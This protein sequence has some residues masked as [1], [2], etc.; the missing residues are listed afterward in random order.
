[1]PL[2]VLHQIK[3]LCKSIPKVEWSGILF[4]TTEGS[5]EKPASFKI[6]LKTILPL[7]MG[8]SAFTEYALDER[9]INFLEEDFD[10]RAQ[11]K[12]GHIHSHNV[13]G[14][15]FSGTDLAELNDNAPSHNFYLS[16]IVNNYMDF[17]AKVAFIGVAQRDIKQVPYM[18]MNS[19]GKTYE[20]EK[21]DFVVNEN[22]M[23]VYDCEINSQKEVI[24]VEEVFS[25]QV[26]KIMEPK[27]K[28][29]YKPQHNPNVPAIVDKNK[30]NPGYNKFRNNHRKNKD[31]NPFNQQKREEDWTSEHNF[32]DFNFNIQEVMEE[33]LNKYSEREVRITNFV[34]QLFNFAS[35][36]VPEDED[37]ADVLEILV[38]FEM[39]PMDIA[40]CI[41]QEYDKDFAT[42]FPEANAADFVQYT[43][44]ALDLLEDFKNYYP[45]IG[46]TIKI[47]TSMITKFV[48][49]DTAKRQQP[50]GQV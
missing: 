18:A 14:V 43:N 45:E 6:T 29:E 15:F 38:E 3:Y 46:M 21:Q 5:I 30:Q 11:W 49:H 47:I 7:D 16:L 39:T 19:Q 25:A 26:A 4:Y 2:E 33:D 28:P 9:F 36:P 24:A 1:M 31:D 27:P 42:H 41:I 37:L 8:T 50:A 32:N 34:K 48:E 20:I 40:T 10:T 22:K 35:T 23:F 17:V 44:E 12:V 13:M